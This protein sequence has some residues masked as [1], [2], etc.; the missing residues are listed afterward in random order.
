[1][2]FGTGT[3]KYPLILW[4][5][6]S[7]TRP[8]LS[9]TTMCIVPLSIPILVRTVL[10]LLSTFSSPVV[11]PPCLSTYDLV[12]WWQILSQ[13]ICISLCLTKGNVVILDNDVH[14][15]IIHIKNVNNIYIWNTFFF[16][17]LSNPIVIRNCFPI[18]S[19]LIYYNLFVNSV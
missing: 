5:T 19:S 11:S 12:V 16:N 9:I 3:F 17:S 15:K 14:V 10:I 8:L 18:R 4:R 6:F 2:S 7:I 1:M 13:N